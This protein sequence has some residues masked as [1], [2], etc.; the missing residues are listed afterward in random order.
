MKRRSR[1]AAAAAA[2]TGTAVAAVAA[3]AAR[4]V[5]PHV[6]IHFPPPPSHLCR[7]C[8]SVRWV[9]WW[10]WALPA[11]LGLYEAEA[12]KAESAGGAHSQRC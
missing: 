10:A 8:V 11:A 2:L 5:V 1:T 12:P 4:L 3:A 6:V 7:H 9:G